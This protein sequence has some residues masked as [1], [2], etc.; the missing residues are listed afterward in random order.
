MSINRNLKIIIVNA[1]L[2][3]SL[4]IL[5]AI[6]DGIPTVEE[7]YVAIVLGLMTFIGQLLL[8]FKPPNP[9][10]FSAD[11]ESGAN[12]PKVGFLFF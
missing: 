3:G 1:L 6:A 4:A 10:T 12:G 2:V 8:Y 9:G 7:L 5:T 11:N